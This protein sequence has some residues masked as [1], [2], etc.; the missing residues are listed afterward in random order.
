[1]TKISVSP[2]MTF[3]DRDGTLTGTAARLLMEIVQALSSPVLDAKTVA[4]LGDGEEG[5]IVYVSNEAGG[6]TLA[7]HDGTNWRRVQD[8]A[9][10]S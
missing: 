8:R 1:M 7:F 6:K 10:V 4:A 2:R 5:Q 9:V 3:V